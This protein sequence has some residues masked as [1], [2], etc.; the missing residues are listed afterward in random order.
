[1]K[2]A[3]ADES[4]GGFLICVRHFELSRIP[5]SGFLIFSENYILT[6][7]LLSFKFCFDCILLSFKLTAHQKEKEKL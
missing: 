4:A 2:L 7:F 3:A 6:H 5:I 1:M